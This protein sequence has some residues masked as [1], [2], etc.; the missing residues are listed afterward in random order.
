MKG[1]A[2]IYGIASYITTMF[3]RYHTRF[4][5]RR[6]HARMAQGSYVSGVYSTRCS[7]DTPTYK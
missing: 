6:F 3:R 5:L 2:Q 7:S 1:D 4:H